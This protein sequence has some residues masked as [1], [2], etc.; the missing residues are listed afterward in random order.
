MTD[1]ANQGSASDG[2]NQPNPGASAPG[3]ASP[4]AS[5]PNAKPAVAARPE[6][7]DAAYWDEKAGAPKL[8]AL[9]K[10]L[11]DLKTFKANE[12]VRRQGVPEKADG[13]KL[14]LPPDVK[15][16]DGFALNDN[17]PRLAPARALAHE[18]GLPQEAFSKLIALDVQM[19]A[20]EH[21]QLQDAIKAEQTKLGANAQ[22]RI[23]AVSTALSGR[24]GAEAAKHL[25][26]M[27]AT[28]AQVE[29]FESLLRSVGPAPFKQDGRDSG[30]ASDAELLKMSPTDRLT[31]LRASQ[32]KAA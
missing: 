15:L 16:P 24:V 23:D 31:H 12:D 29:A 10:D 19:K 21:G 6:Y 9:A 7:L 28:A 11:G 22:Q 5:D 3:G 32:N 20:A 25:I 13:Y 17:D 26:P 27:M 14:T 2:A 8:D 30:A 4:P 1:Q 18:L